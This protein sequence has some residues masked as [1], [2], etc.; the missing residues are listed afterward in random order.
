M[1]STPTKR[2][3]LLPFHSS[4]VKLCYYWHSLFLLL[5]KYTSRLATDFKVI[6]ITL[7]RVTLS[8]PA[9]TDCSNLFPTTQLSLQWSNAHSQINTHSNFASLLVTQHKFEHWEIYDI[10]F[11]FTPSFQLFSVLLTQASL[12]LIGSTSEQPHSF[13]FTECSERCQQQGSNKSSPK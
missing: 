2:S 1:N 8:H 13:I 6:I 4:S 3:S 5:C 11:L 7:A 9:I 10:M 12:Q